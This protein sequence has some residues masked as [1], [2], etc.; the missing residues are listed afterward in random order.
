[1]AAIG[2]AAGAVQAVGVVRVVD[3]VARVLDGDLAPSPPHSG[4]ALEFA[5]HAV[6][7][8]V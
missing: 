2:V 6:T 8:Y 3:Q 7:R 5:E 4:H 1:V